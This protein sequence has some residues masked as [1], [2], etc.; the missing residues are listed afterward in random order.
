[1]DY[2]KIYQD[3]MEARLSVKSERI[4]EKRNGSYFERHH[5]LPLSLG[6][7]KSYALGS[8]NIV[9]FSLTFFVTLKP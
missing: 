6:G 9:L 8:D 2:K 3:L 7:D 1:M 5:I 4:V